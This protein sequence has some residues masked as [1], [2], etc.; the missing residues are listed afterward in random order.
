MFISNE[1]KNITLQGSSPSQNTIGN[2]K[3]DLQN[4]QNFSSI[5]S[6]LESI[7]SDGDNYYFS[8][9]LTMKN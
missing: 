7:S 9:K 8:I 6:P 1:S 3:D 4:T 2:F 5:T